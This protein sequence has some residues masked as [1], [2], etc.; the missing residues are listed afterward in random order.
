MNTAQP[1]LERTPQRTDEFIRAFFGPGNTVWRSGRLV[2][3]IDWTSAELGDSR[4]DV[5]Q[6]RIDLALSLGLDAADTFLD[7][8]QAQAPRRLPDI[9]YFDLFRGLRALI[10][11]KH[12]LKGYHDAGLTQITST[13]AHDRIEAF[14]WQALNGRHRS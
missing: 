2:G 5:S 1:R 7:A 10:S 12:W 3:V 9:W 8:Y 11:Y 6:C 14:L 13:L 4:T